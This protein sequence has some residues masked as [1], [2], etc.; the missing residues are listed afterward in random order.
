MTSEP[1]L[2]SLLHLAIFIAAVGAVGVVA[3]AVIERVAG[4]ESPLI[5]RHHVVIAIAVVAAAI[6][7]ER[8][9]HLVE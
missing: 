3:V 1:L 4:S 9:Y 5:K 6:V 8:I 2:D 7:A